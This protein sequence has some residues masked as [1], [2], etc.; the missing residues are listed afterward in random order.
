M[1][2]WIG[3][4]L[5]MHDLFQSRSACRTVAEEFGVNRDVHFLVS[6]LRHGSIVVSIDYC[7]EACKS[8][9]PLCVI[10]RF[11]FN[12]FEFISVIL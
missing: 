9:E 4:A 1:R 2:F 3:L 12:I 8:I 6:M 11:A 10:L 7:S 5:Y